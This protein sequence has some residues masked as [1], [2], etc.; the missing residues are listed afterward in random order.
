M[1]YLWLFMFVTV[2]LGC[3][4]V[5]PGTCRPNT[6]GGAGGADSWAVGAGVGVSAAAGTYGADPPK[7]PLAAGDGANPCEEPAM[8]KPANQYINCAA[9][10]LDP[11]ACSEACFD[12]G[13]GCVPFALHPY[14][15]EDGQGKLT[16]CKNG[17]PT[18]TC[19]WTF[20]NTDACTMVY[21]VGVKLRW[22]CE[23][24]GGG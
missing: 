23:Y 9:R 21:T 19:T 17:W 11:T 16:F 7:D 15:S 24:A 2:L 8:G 6:T 10:G 3:N 14:K 12:V 5:V 4:E 1:K 22:F 20:P 18:T 13:A